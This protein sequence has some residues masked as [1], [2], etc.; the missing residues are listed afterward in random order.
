MKKSFTRMLMT[1]VMTLGAAAA[2]AQPVIT[3]NVP[4]AFRSVA[5]MQPAGMYAITRLNENLILR[6]QA[7]GASIL[8]AA[9]A[10]LGHSKDGRVKLV[11]RCGSESGCALAEVWGTDGVGREVPTP[12]L[13]PVETA[14]MAVIYAD[15]SAVAS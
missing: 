12:K 2:Y 5:K 1:V 6:N 14:R 8:T 3:A 10:V 9:S 13:K 7:T 4:F 15:R 11:F